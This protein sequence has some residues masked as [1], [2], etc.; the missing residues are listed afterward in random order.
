MSFITIFTEFGKFINGFNYPQ[1]LCMLIKLNLNHVNSELDKTRDRKMST[2]LVMVGCKQ[3]SYKWG[4]IVEDGD[5][6]ETSTLVS[7][8]IDCQK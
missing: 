3:F 1:K 4:I 8:K 2:V 5:N 6:T 7:L